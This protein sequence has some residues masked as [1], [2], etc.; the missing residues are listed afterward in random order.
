MTI[1]DIG[2]GTPQGGGSILTLSGKI[3]NIEDS[4]FTVG[5]PLEYNSKSIPPQILILYF[6]IILPITKVRQI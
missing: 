5:F 2:N 6:T 4:E 1:E 3:N